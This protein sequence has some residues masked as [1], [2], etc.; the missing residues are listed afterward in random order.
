MI[1]ECEGQESFVAACQ[2]EVAFEIPSEIKVFHEY[3]FNQIRMGHV[4]P[5]AKKLAVVEGLPL[6]CQLE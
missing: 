4:C 3:C 2:G 1:G 6:A 5:F